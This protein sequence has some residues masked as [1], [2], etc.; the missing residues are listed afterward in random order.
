MI[1]QYAYIGYVLQDQ[2]VLDQ[3]P[4]SPTDFDF[5]LVGTFC[6]MQRLHDKNVDITIETLISEHPGFKEYAKEIIEHSA[7]RSSIKYHWEKIRQI[8]ERRNLEAIPRLIDSRP[9]DEIKADIEEVLKS[10]E[11]DCSSIV[12]AKDV[13]KETM[14]ELDRPIE[15]HEIGL[16][17]IDRDLFVARQDL[18]VVGGRPSMGKTAFLLKWVKTQAKDG[19]KCLVFSLEMGRTQLMKRMASAESSVD[20][21]KIKR[22]EAK[23]DELTRY[24]EGMGRIASLPIF[25]DDTAG[26]S[27]QQIRSRVRREKPDIVFIDYLQLVGCKGESR[28]HEIEEISRKLKIIAKENNIPV[29]ALSQLSRTLEQRPNKRPIMSDLRESGAIEQDADI[30]LFLYREAVYCEYLKQGQECRCSHTHDKRAVEI[31]IAKQREGELKSSFANF[32]GEYTK[33]IDLP[34]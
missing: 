32:H 25:I 4:L 8:T 30:I 22:R 26:I 31:I 21:T 33:F 27:I 20:A 9:T 11:R 2:K 29:V 3:Y 7:G 1:S 17:W 16:K 34:N 28:R 23:S 13:A 19:K 14:R 18:V 5:E 12:S 15:Q 10:T 6:A 24:V